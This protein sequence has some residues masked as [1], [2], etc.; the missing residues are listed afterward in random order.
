[1]TT[2][3]KNKIIKELKNFPEKKINSLLDY[4]FFLKFEDKIKIPN[5]LTEKALDDADN[6][7]NLNSYTSLDDFFNK[8]ES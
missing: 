6:K 4:I 5:K 1:M 7:N 2:L 3:I 8:M